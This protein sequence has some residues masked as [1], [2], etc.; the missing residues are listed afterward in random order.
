MLARRDGRER[1]RRGSGGE[2]SGADEGVP[3]V[4]LDRARGRTAVGGD[5]DA[6]R[7]VASG[8]W[9]VSAVVDVVRTVT[10]VGGEADPRC[11]VPSG[12]KVAV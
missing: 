6:E 7:D 8:D 5:L 9:V 2:D 4:D 11:V 12:S 1:E 3:V 10:E